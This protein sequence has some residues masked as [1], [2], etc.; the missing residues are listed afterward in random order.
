MIKSCMVCGAAF[1]GG[2]NVYVCDACK[3]RLNGPKMCRIC[4][5]P[6]PPD[7]RKLYYCSSECAKVAQHRRVRMYW[8]NSDPDAIIERAVA[9]TKKD[10]EAAAK[11]T[12]RERLKIAEFQRK[13]QK[14]MTPEQLAEYKEKRRIYNRE[15]K[16]KQRE[17]MKNNLLDEP[18]KCSICGKLLSG[19]ARKY[20]AE[21]RKRKEV[22]V[23]YCVIC[24]K[25]I[26]GRSF[27]YCSEECR[28]VGRVKSMYKSSIARIRKENGEK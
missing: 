27:R 4:G 3:A 6:I 28:T 17:R 8:L 20:C 26:D 5:K 25:Q 21:C 19:N 10:P 16:R 23:R 15:Y 13:K 14:E 9:R 2:P 12:E 22:S 7:S 24:G 1:D 18:R 11:K